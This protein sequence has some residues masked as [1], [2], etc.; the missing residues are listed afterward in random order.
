MNV[1]N[2]TPEQKQL[3][4][5]WVEDG[6]DLNAIQKRLNEEC[7]LQLTFM[8]T[9]FLLLDLGLEIKT[10]PQKESPA[11]VSPAMAGA[12]PP[13]A[14]IPPLPAQQSPLTGAPLTDNDLPHGNLDLALDEVTPP[15]MVVSGKV[16]FP[17]GAYGQWFVDSQYRVGIDPS[18]AS[19]EPTE[20]D[21]MIFER[22]I[23]RF[24]RSQM[25]TL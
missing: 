5:Q 15:G 11:P 13:A 16:K 6:L 2:L 7:A 18:P 25:G 19:P 20:K 14:S 10:A 4:T 21:M 17:S 22:E 8:D 12:V 1:N 3:I 9:R 23:E 24:I